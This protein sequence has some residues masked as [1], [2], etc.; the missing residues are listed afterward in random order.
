MNASFSLDG[1]PAVQRGSVRANMT[2]A[3]DRIIQD[4]GRQPKSQH[5]EKDVLMLSHAFSSPRNVIERYKMK[6]EKLA[7]WLLAIA[8]QYL[9]V[10]YHNWNHALDVFFFAYYC[11]VQGQADRFFNFQDILAL[12]VGALAHDV[13]HFGVTNNFLTTTRS[14]L[15][16]IYN[17]QSVLE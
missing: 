16:A 10:P 11:V 5:C 6:V 8:G 14:D 9:P 4:L 1:G 13:G 12:F 17:D 2:Q 7:G 15:A 3:A